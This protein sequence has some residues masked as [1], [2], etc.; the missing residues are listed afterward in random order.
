MWKTTENLGQLGELARENKRTLRKAL[1]KANE[2]LTL[3][4]SV[5]ALSNTIDT[6]SF[7]D[8]DDDDNQNTNNE[9]EDGNSNNVIPGITDDDNDNRTKEKHKNF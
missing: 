9:E 4:A 5:D 3:Q 8:G 2:G 6:D 1:R 7:A